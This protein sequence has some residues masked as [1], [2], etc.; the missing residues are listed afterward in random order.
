MARAK[1]QKTFHSRMPH[2]ADERRKLRNRA[3]HLANIRQIEDDKEKELFLQIGLDNDDHYGIPYKY[4]DEILRP[5]PITLIPQSEKIISGVIPYRG[6]LI[7]VLDLSIM[8]G[9]KQSS[10]TVTSKIKSS[11]LVIVS[12]ENVK[13]ALLVHEV[14][15]NCHYRPENLGPS[16]NTKLEVK[17][18]PIL[19][20]FNG[21][22]AIIDLHRLLTSYHVLLGNT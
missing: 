13:L 21:K 11:W 8:L 15:G 14:V 10:E 9:I 20:I 17:D 22:I 12:I 3:I 1:K 7:A 19:G 16:M 4:L 5:K 18:D 6:E 2:K